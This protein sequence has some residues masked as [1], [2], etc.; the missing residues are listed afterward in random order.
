MGL[1]A[2]KSPSSRR[3][4]EP[5]IT[6]ASTFFHQGGWVFASLRSL[7]LS[8]P[9]PASSCST[10]HPTTLAPAKGSMRLR[11]ARHLWTPGAGPGL[12]TRAHSTAPAGLP[13][14]WLR[15]GLETPLGG[16]SWEQRPQETHA[17]V[18]LC[19]SPWLQAPTVPNGSLWVFKGAGGG[20]GSPGLDSP[21][22]GR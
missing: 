5:E 17:A 16:L 9:R 6:R 4:R 2:P 10:L 15:L 13:G 21:V 22:T 7:L 19:L 11:A 18:R 20:L 1:F 8:P 14:P 12:W 3:E